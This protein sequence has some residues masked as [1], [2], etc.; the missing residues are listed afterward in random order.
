M[1][2]KDFKLIARVVKG[3]DVIVIKSQQ[4]LIAD[5]FA[6]MLSDTNPLFDR[7]KFLKACGV[8]ND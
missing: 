5:D 8:K 7:D 3:L 1:T 4:V 2:R 6:N